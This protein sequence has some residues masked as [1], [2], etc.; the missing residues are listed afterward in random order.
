MTCRIDI[1]GQNG[2]DPVHYHQPWI[3]GEQAAKNGVKCDDNPYTHP[4][5]RK[6]WEMGWYGLL[7]GDM[8]E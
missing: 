2:G 3:D 5:N 7:E 1:I 4:D 8:E 6:L